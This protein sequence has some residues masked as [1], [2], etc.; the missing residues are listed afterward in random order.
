MPNWNHIVREHLAVLRLPPEREI[1]IVEEQA[2][3]LESAYEDALA[4]G[5]SE[6]EAEARALQGYDW[7]ILEC[8]LSR[9][10]RPPASRVLPPS[11][12]LIGRKGGLRMDSLLQDLRYGARMLFKNPGFTLI[13]VV[14]LALGVGVNT[15]IFSVVNAVL[16]RPLPYSEPD[17]LVMLWERRIREGSDNNA[18]AP[19]DFRDWRAR[20]QVFTNIAAM[21][22]I[23]LNLSGGNEPERVTTGVVSASFFEVLGV[24][25]MLGRGFLAEEE[26]A[27][28]NR[29]VI[30]NHDLW[31][32]RFGADRDIVGRQISLNGAPF[33]VVGVLPPSFRFPNEELALWLP[34]DAN[35]QDMQ[36][37]LNHF[38]SVYARTKPGVTLS[39]ARAEME[40]I[41]EQLR[42]EYPQENENR[43][44]FVIPLHEDLSGNLSRPLLILFAAV[45]LV[46]LIACANVANLQLI[47][48]VARQKE[49]AVR[50]ALGA[51]R[52]RIA[53]QLLTESALLA[54]LGTMMGMSLAWWSAG[55][56]TSLLPRGIL[57][58]TVARL[59]LRVLGFTLAISLLTGALSSL[60][61]LLQASSVKL[62][63]MLKEGGRG[64][65]AT[66][67]RARSAVVVVEVALAIVLLIGAGLLI[68]S[69]WKLQ[70]V[71]PGF[72]PQNALTAQIVLPSAR[73]REPERRA[74]FFQQLSE[75]ARALPG[76]RAVGAISILP[77]GG[78]WSRTSIAIEGRAEMTDLLPQL[79]P[80]IH[81][82]T[83]TPDYFQAMGIPLLNGRFPTWKDDSKAPLVALINQ[84]AAQRYWPGQNPLGHRVQIGGGAPWREVIGVVGD[85]KEQ[86]LDQ[87]INPEVYFAWAQDSPWGGT[88]VM[89]GQN[90]ASLA[91]ALRN[92]ARQLDKDLPLSNLRLLE[93]VVESSIAT[94]RSYMLLLALFAGIALTLA[95]IG[96]YGVMAYGVSQ[97][98]HELGVRLALGAQT[99]DVLLLVLRQGLRMALLGVALGLAAA[100]VVTRLMKKM[101][102]EVSATDPLTVVFVTGSLVV[103]ALLACWF[104]ARRATKVDP[105]TSLRH[106]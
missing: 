26:Q 88:L 42:Q 12:E 4:A 73:Y 29:V 28:R 93:E 78:G 67:Q 92:Q 104:P 80:R 68:R 55:M 14:T 18:V 85:V 40:R 84:T 56:L 13:A 15:A 87:E 1:E 10:E 9:A 66:H 60:A 103:V 69:F 89:R 72:A 37:R 41:G 58:L 74:R 2:L 43:T 21:F 52:W 48:A 64:V 61:A 24:K 86:G 100:W 44:A 8:E 20:N 16:L 49:L 79:R 59:D 91:P 98:T 19:A 39:Q 32:R 25:P 95:A 30:M 5:S 45:G 102:F 97:R 76:V 34:L 36:T 82:R 54:A 7:R 75:Q 94:P 99:R 96:I 35:A 62:N 105:L 83:V 47:R 38:L 71:S 51:G 17:K 50:A 27:G 22:A 53:R 11:L 46:L 3:H 6:A 101:L 81:P 63:D 77:L 65:G 31:Q 106:D 57:H 70:S 90:V 33:E 23:P